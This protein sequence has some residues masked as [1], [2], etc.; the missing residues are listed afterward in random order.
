MQLVSK[1]QGNPD[2]AGGSYIPFRAGQALRLTDVL[3]AVLTINEDEHMKL[4]IRREHRSVHDDIRGEAVHLRRNALALGHSIPPPTDVIVTMPGG[5]LLTSQGTTTDD[6][7]ESLSVWRGSVAGPV[8]AGGHSA[9][10][11]D[12]TITWP[13]KRPMPGYL[14]MCEFRR[15]C[16]DGPFPPKGRQ[17]LDITMFGDIVDLP[18]DPDIS[19]DP[20]N[21]VDASSE[22]EEPMDNS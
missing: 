14:K 20:K 9:P 17:R 2:L 4:A 10:F 16:I 18:N 13:A 22:A 12:V 5:S 8:Y 7:G 6:Y 15:V 19:Y 1:H 3:K 21:C 11:A